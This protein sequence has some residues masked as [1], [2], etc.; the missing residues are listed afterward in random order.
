MKLKQKKM[1]GLRK[2]DDEENLWTNILSTVNWE[3]I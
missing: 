2:F 3:N 1:P